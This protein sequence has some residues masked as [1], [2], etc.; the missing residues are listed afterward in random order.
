MHLQ[1]A[2][3]SWHGHACKRQ[4]LA[5][6]GDQCHCAGV[7]RCELGVQVRA[8]RNTRHLP[9]LLRVRTTPQ[10]QAGKQGCK[11]GQSSILRASASQVPKAACPKAV[12]GCSGGLRP[13]N[14][15]C[16]SALSVSPTYLLWPMNAL[17]STYLPWQQHSST[18]TL[19]FPVQLT[20]PSNATKF[21]PLPTCSAP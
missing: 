7:A 5:Q 6:R 11:R 8:N 2:H 17:S 20:T 14:R 12:Q 1:L 19:M 13:E 9:A 3:V 21:P 16:G 15:Q 4:P 10:L 18:P